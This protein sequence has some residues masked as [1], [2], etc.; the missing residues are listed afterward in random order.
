MTA[1]NLGLHRCPSG[2]LI[3][4]T[5]HRFGSGLRDEEQREVKGL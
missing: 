1:A 4:I 5:G 3:V 2:L